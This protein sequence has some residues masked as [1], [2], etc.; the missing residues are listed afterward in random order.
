[1]RKYLLSSV[2]C[3]LCVLGIQAQVTLKGVAVKMNSDFTPVAGVE[4]VVQGGV[5]TLTDGA[6]TFILKL[7]HMESDAFF[8]ISVSANRVWRSLIS[9]R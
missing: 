9:K 5:P 4:V 6:G 8:L 3:G 2:F 7:P 1:M